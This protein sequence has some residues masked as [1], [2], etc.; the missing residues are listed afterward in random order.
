MVKYERFTLNNGLRVLVHEDKST[1]MAVLNILYDVGA[2]DE[3]PDKTGFAHLFEHLM[4]GGSVNIP[5]FDLPLQRVGGESNAFTSNDITNYYI[6]LPAINL[7][8][9]FWLESDRMLSLAFSEKSLET[10]KQVVSEEFKQRYLNQPYGDV[11]LKLR[12]L[13]YKQHPYKWATI[14]KEISHIELAS[15][16]DV[17]D[18]F[19][20][21]YTPQNAI[22][23]IAGD[24]DVSV[25]KDLA[26]KWFGSIS[27]GTKY[28]RNLEAEPKQLEARREVVTANVPVNS[29]Y[30]AFHMSDRRS[31]DYYT[32]DLISDI[33]S[34]GNSS[35]LYRRLVKEQSLFSEINAYLLGSLDNGLFIV[36]GKPLPSTTMELA[37]NAVWEQL[38]DLQNTPVLGY[39]LEKVKNKIES[40]M[41]FAEMSIL[42]KAMN[43]AYF[44]LLGN[45]DMLNDEVVKYLNVSPED[46][47]KTAQQIFQLENSSTL[48]YL[49][50]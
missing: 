36:E 16:Q 21:H 40:T 38:R 22:L 2:R 3:E 18:F 17:K 33:L 14:G 11:W 5:Q 10:Q 30:M 45:A 44:E 13:A 19:K 26:E 28:I 50:S 1:P 29:L 35:R 12:P 20:K 34:R 6:T 8:T 23:V 4:F 39:E 48:F 27:S 37:E 24:V 49:A 25:V 31:K 7:E 41:V 15:I 43:L 47:Q 32:C 42:D 46:I 9:A